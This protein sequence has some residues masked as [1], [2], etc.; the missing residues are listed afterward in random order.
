MGETDIQMDKIPYRKRTIVV[1]FHD[2][3]QLHEDNQ[4]YKFELW[5][6]PPRPLLADILN[7]VAGDINTEDDALV[8]AALNSMY[9]ALSEIIVDCNIEGSDFTNSQSV[10]ESFSSTQVGFNLY[11]DASIAAVQW[12][13]KNADSVKKVLTPLESKNSSGGDESIKE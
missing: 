3:L 4:G 13:L 1:D 11:L 6:D 9:E 5:K 12:I 8:E 7:A 10:K 2:D